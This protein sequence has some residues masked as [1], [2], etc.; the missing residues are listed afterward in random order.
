MGLGVLVT[1]SRE[2]LRKWSA[3]EEGK[4][5]FETREND[6][7]FRSGGGGPCKT[8]GRGGGG[9]ELSE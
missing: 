3:E 1:E 5:Q 8:R 7:F 6:F 2:M 4:S 9:S